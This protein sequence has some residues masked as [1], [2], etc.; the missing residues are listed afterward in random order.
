MNAVVTA[1][2]CEELFEDREFALRMQRG[3]T[4]HRALLRYFTER[5]VSLE[6]ALLLAFA[7]AA[8]S[9]HCAIAFSRALD[10][11]TQR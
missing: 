2:A 8:G 11:V 3:A 7:Y 4:T 1:A 5:G 6:D 10:R 9:E